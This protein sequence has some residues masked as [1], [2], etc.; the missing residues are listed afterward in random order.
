MAP[1]VKVMPEWPAAYHLCLYSLPVVIHLLASLIPATT[2]AAVPVTFL[3]EV[4]S[5]VFKHINCAPRHLLCN[6]MPTSTRAI[7]ILS[8]WPA[9]RV[10]ATAH[11]SSEACSQTHQQTSAALHPS[12]RPHKIHEPPGQGRLLSSPLCFSLQPGSSTDKC[13]PETLPLKACKIHELPR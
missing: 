4:I 2:K 6:I 7:F 10:H 12:L 13:S 11:Y 5:S 3:P 1:S 8:S 9:L